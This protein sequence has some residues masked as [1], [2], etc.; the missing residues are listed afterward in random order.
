MANSEDE[1]FLNF[2]YKTLQ[3]EYPEAF[4][5]EGKLK[6]YVP[7]RQYMRS[8]HPHNLGRPLYNNQAKNL[9]MMGARGYGKS[10]SVGVG[11]VAHEYLFDGK[12]H[13]DPKADVT[14]AEIVMGA[15]DAKYSSETLDK[16]KIALDQMPGAQE[17]NGVYY[18]APFSKRYLGS[19][20]PGKQITA[21]YKKKEGG[22]WK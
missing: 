11:I 2:K 15:G 21:T 22:A 9:F 5:P 14:A 20:Q 3:K 19:W 16:T 17:I 12:T 1:S 4:T 13:Y 10:Y 18:P 8:T 7:A 6:K